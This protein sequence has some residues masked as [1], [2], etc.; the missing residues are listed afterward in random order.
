ML[1]EGGGRERPLQRRPLLLHA[2]KRHSSSPPAL[3]KGRTPQPSY[4]LCTETVQSSVP[5]DPG[6]RS[7]CQDVLTRPFCLYCPGDCEAHGRKFRLTTNH[8]L[9]KQ[10]GETAKRFHR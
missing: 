5:P 2:D 4:P 10:R 6:L 3:P 1:E 9:I 7:A 8:H